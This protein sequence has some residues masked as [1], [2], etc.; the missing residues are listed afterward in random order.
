[1]TVSHYDRLG[2]SLDAT[3]EEIRLAYRELAWRHHPDRT[4]R[5][6]SAEMMEIN[7]AWRVLSDPTLRHSYDAGL[8]SADRSASSVGRA[9]SPT[10]NTSRPNGGVSG[11]ASATPARFPW[12]FVL[13]FLIVAVAVIL[14]MGV[15]TD[16]AQPT[17]IDNVIRV[18]SC[19]DVD[20]VRREA[21]EVDCDGPHDAQVAQLVPFDATCPST[22]TAYRDRQGLGQV[23]VLES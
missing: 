9:S 2:V 3:T 14:F 1:M 10:W 18:G 6:T 15:I 17:P 7:E 4:G 13:G 11:F 19:V 20:P 23:C 12:R 22:A 21:W 8:E 5:A 16:S